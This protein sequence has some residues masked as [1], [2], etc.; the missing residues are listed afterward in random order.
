MQ[1]ASQRREGVGESVGALDVDAGPAVDSGPAVDASRAPD[2]PL[3]DGLASAVLGGVVAGWLIASVDAVARHSW[4]GIDRQEHMALAAT[5]FA[6][7]GV[8]IG[9]GIGGASSV[10]ALLRRRLAGRWVRFAIP[11][12]LGLLASVA[13]AGTV[14]GALAGVASRDEVAA[15]RLFRG[16]LGACTVGTALLV[17]AVQWTAKRA[18]Q[19]RAVM[20]PFA[21]GCALV[22]LGTL[23]A[24]ADLHVMPA[25]YA[26]VHEAAEVVAWLLKGTGSA[27]ALFAA[28]RRWPSVGAV[29]RFASALTV[30][31]AVVWFSGDRTSEQASLRHIRREPH[32]VGRMMLR[33]ELARDYLQDPLAWRGKQDASLARLIKR[34][35]IVTIEQSPAWDLP[36]PPVDEPAPL[37]PKNVVVIYVDTLRADVA[38]EPSVMPH[39]AKL[40]AE[41]ISFERAYATASDTVSSLPVLTGGC[42]SQEPCRGDLL[43]IAKARGLPHAVAIPKSAQRFLAKHAPDFAFEDVLEVTDYEDGKR[44]WGYGADQ[45][46]ALE[47][48]QRALAWIDEHRD[49]RFFLWAF[50]FDVHNWM[51]L[52]AEH[53]EEMA[54]RH[55]IER[56]LDD[57]TWRYRA[58][59]A[60][61]DA[62]IGVLLDGL[63]QRGLYDDTVLLFVSDHGE[64]LGHQGH[65]QHAVFL[66][67]SLVHVPMMLRVP[68]VSPSV[69]AAPV[70]HVD[71]A[72]SLARILDPNADMRLY[73]G[74]D[75]LAPPRGKAALPILLFS[76]RKDELLR[77]G[78]IARDAPYYKLELPIDSVEPDVLDLTAESPDESDVR[79]KSPARTLELLSM[80][81]TSPIF[82]RP[83]VDPAPAP[84]ASAP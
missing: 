10:V 4:I 47:L 64:G 41:S 49:E 22:A 71:V 68:G 62:G 57:K 32:Y 31:W 14:E 46:T 65:W 42:Y 83:E 50:H 29:L 23:V 1:P 53:L 51:Q 7:L 36:R 44:V 28:T 60:G 63:R 5:M 82:P 27:L 67:D 76:M 73:H 43:A 80:L 79:D 12:A 20:A 58:A 8:L 17:V 33:L 2:R 84:S 78:L 52:N 11:A 25:L 15:T 81:V 35:D 39:V 38:A 30:A 77:V 59:A 74:V 9:G 48:S 75:L 34:Y 56:T 37:P 66:W 6:A 3:V 69:V 19:R 26:Q 72:P 40:R 13:V 18:V 70:G 24:W 55:Q 61:V 21:L 54:E 16:A 45:S